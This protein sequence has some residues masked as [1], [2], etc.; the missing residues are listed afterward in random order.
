[1]K[2]RTDKE[3]LDWLDMQ[4]GDM[5]WICRPSTTGRGWRLHT[6]PKGDFDTGSNSVREAIDKAIEEDES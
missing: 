1:M 5:Q 6:F 3:R 4:D 2:T